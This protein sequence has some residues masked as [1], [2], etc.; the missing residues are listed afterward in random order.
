[1]LEFVLPSPILLLILLKPC[2]SNSTFFL[3]KM[4][5]F[6]E[7]KLGYKPSL[8]S[9]ISAASG[10]ALKATL[11]KELANFQK[12]KAKAEDYSKIVAITT[13]KK[14]T[15]SK[16]KKS[17][18]SELPPEDQVDEELQAS[19]I[20]LQRKSALYAEMENSEADDDN[21]LVD[22]LKK[23]EYEEDLVE[24]V[25][26]LGRTRLVKKSVAESKSM[27]GFVKPGENTD[28]TTGTSMMTAD[29]LMERERQRWEKES[30]NEISSECFKSNSQSLQINI[31]MQDMKLEPSELGTTSLVKIWKKGRHN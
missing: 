24:V 4:A 14:F 2:V 3:T 6:E 28:E 8:E 15:K 7:D 31:M 22:F 10:I 25:D 5:S 20:S 18:V 1:M 30:Q 11:N 21:L 12:E 26:E 27:M 19:W 17:N 23:H 9:T 13:G 16:P 29:M